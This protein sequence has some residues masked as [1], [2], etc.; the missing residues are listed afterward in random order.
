M[1]Q[2]V[3]SFEPGTSFTQA[4]RQPLPKQATFPPYHSDLVTVSEASHFSQLSLSTTVRD[5]AGTFPIDVHSPSPTS[6]EKLL[7]LSVT[8]PSASV[9][10][11]ILSSSPLTSRND[12]AQV[13]LYQPSVSTGSSLTSSATNTATREQETLVSNQPPAEM[14]VHLQCEVMNAQT[15]KTIKCTSSSG[16]NH[17][18]LRSIKLKV[19]KYDT[20]A[21]YTP[22]Q[23]NLSA[24]QSCYVYIINIGS[25]GDQTVLVPNEF[26]EH[27]YLEAGKVMMFPS[28]TADYE[29]ELDE[30]CGLETIVLMA[31]QSPLENCDQAISDCG[32]FRKGSIKEEMPVELHRGIK[33][34]PK[35][36]RQQPIGF[37]EI[38]FAVSE[39]RNTT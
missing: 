29:F 37:L 4:N 16:Q 13:T 27:N 32:A 35:R 6:R 24:S 1:L 22:L 30:N 38:Q 33:V 34:K 20:V 25:A 31:Y 18:L 5:R 8:E 23:L 12:K 9:S 17:P 19:K 21:P 3:N 36:Q 2:R 39:F 14:R 15:R 26:E 28:S 7:P 10:T 11:E